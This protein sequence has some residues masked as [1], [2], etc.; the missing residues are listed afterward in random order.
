MVDYVFRAKKPSKFQHTTTNK[1]A[2]VV[3]QTQC[4]SSTFS[5]SLFIVV[6]HKKLC[7]SHLVF[8]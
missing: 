1:L 3:L 7:I 4:V 5:P 6:I 2:V 8:K